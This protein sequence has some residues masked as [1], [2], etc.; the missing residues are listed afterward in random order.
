MTTTTE[1]PADAVRSP[2]RDRFWF[3]ALV[4][5]AALALFALVA[6]RLVHRD[7]VAAWAVVASCPAGPV[8]SSIEVGTVLD[9]AGCATAPT[10]TGPTRG[11]PILPVVLPAA[12]GLEPEITAVSSDP[13]TRTVHVDYAAP[14]AAASS[15]GGTVLVFVEVPPTA[16]PGTPFTLE[17]AT[18]PVTVT[19]VRTG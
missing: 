3:Q 2:L 12:A 5:V 11:W 15:V 10:S 19:A 13:R 8:A 4:V 17:G 14:S 7:V 6:A 1:R 18:G 9:T 16:L